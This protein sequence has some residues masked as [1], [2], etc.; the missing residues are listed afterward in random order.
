[1]IPLYAF[2]KRNGCFRKR[3]G[4]NA[5]FAILISICR[6]L[7]PEIWIHFPGCAKFHFYEFNGIQCNW[8]WTWRP[9]KSIHACMRSVP[10]FRRCKDSYCT[11]CSTRQSLKSAKQENR[12]ASRLFNSKVLFFSPCILTPKLILF[13]CIVLCAYYSP[14]LFENCEL[15]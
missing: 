6:F 4:T 9:F 10:A 15:M 14:I 3:R 5:T 2:F 1:M 12:K 7:V 13:N 11:I 8:N